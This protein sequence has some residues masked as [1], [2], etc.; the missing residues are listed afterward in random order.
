MLHLEVELARY[1]R[2]LQFV[3]DHRAA[4]AQLQEKMSEMNALLQRLKNPPISTSTEWL[5]DGEGSPYSEPRV[6]RNSYLAGEV[7]E[8]TM[9][10][11]EEEDQGPGRTG[12]LMSEPSK[13]H[14]FG[15]T[16]IELPPS[17]D[18]YQPESEVEPEDA[19][20]PPPL[21][22]YNVEPRSRRRRDS[23]FMRQ[24]DVLPDAA[25]EPTKSL[26]SK[27]PK[28][29]FDEKEAD[30]SP[31]SPELNNL[32]FKFSKLIDRAA[33]KRMTD[34]E[35]VKRQKDEKHDSENDLP[36][37]VRN[38]KVVEEAGTDTDV[39]KQPSKNKRSSTSSGVVPSVA[40]RK[41]LGPSKDHPR[42]PRTGSML[43]LHREHKHR[44]CPVPHEDTASEV[45]LP[46][47][48]K[49]RR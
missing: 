42:T 32:D 13:R 11:I 41:A 9:P 48:R 30:H 44:S 17:G 16:E 3:E 43:I 25:P 34:N 4:A 8:P 14:N 47:Q 49:D 20:L 5:G 15:F 39:G 29:K 6:V 36:K 40:A 10:C 21:P 37:I 33:P 26:L 24:S 18:H 2:E 46:S 19:P 31:P 28:R 23:Q 12:M 1:D 27:P 7:L 45:R 22:M 35:Q 38:S